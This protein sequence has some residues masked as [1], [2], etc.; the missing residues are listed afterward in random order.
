MV[1][2]LKIQRPS[3]YID[4]EVNVIRHESFLKVALAF[5]DI[6][7]VGMSHLGLRILYDIVNNLSFA[8]AERV[9]HPW[10]DMENALRTSGEP[11]RSLE[12][13]RPVTGFDV[14]GFSLQ[15]ELCYTSVLNMLDLGGVPL[16]SADRKD[17][18]PL[19]IAGG[20]CTVNPM[21]MAPFMDA[22]LI[23]DGEEAVPELLGVLHEWKKGGSRR[24]DEV[25][26]TLAQVEGVYV[27]QIHD[28]DAAVRIRRRYIYS[29]EE[30][31]CPTAPIV[32]YAQIV[33][34]RVNI[35]VSRGCTK[36]CRFCQAGMVYRPLRE[37]SP[38]KVLELASA[39]LAN[40]GYE[41][42]AFTSLS[43]GDYTGLL[44]LLKG[45]NQRFS[46]K[47]ISVS[48]PSLR[49]RAVNRDV[50]QEIR[51]VRKTGFTIAPE[52]GTTR[53]RD[54]INKDF[55]AEDYARALD[56]L[57]Q[58]GWQ[59][60][61]LYF[62]LGL[63]TERQ[64]DVEAIIDMV[65]FAQKTARKY[66]KRQVKINV[67][68]SP[69]VPKAHTPFQWC[70]QEDASVIREKKDFL[71]SRL[72]RVQFRGHDERMSMLEAAF[73]RGGT[74]LSPLLEASWRAGARLDGWSEAFRME[75]WEKGQEDSGLE[76]AKQAAKSYERDEP[77]PWEMIETGVSKKFLYR[78]YE[79]ALEAKMSPD[80]SVGKCTGC[81][82]G[83]RSEG[84][85][86]EPA[87][88]RE[89]K[90]MVRSAPQ[91]PV[92]KPIRVRVCFSKTGP[93]RYLSHRELITHVT[94]ALRRVGVTLEFSKGFHP[95]PRISFG[96]PLGVGVAGTNEFFDMEILPLISLQEIKERLNGVLGEG[97]EIKDLAPIDSREQ[98]LQA[99]VTRYGYD[100]VCPD[101]ERAVAFSERREC[102]V[103]R[104][105]GAVDIRPLV[106]SMERKTPDRVRLML[107]DREDKRVR[108]EEIA[109]E[110]F[111]VELAELD[112]TRFALFGKKDGQWSPPLEMERSW[113]QVVS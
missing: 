6:Y 62:M 35:E 33:H 61:K 31:P 12:F 56:T 107:V 102:I 110:V 113:P 104:E 28:G 103:K 64:E 49:V 8:S 89:S 37:R 81:G 51:S 27:P 75:A 18:D 68:A 66:S 11:L 79:R 17:G 109:R 82:L 88:Y 34:D 93:L 25:L 1:N 9:F 77:L 105:K 52:A 22:F 57:F 59:T 24:R 55:S 90:I 39:S 54:V 94:R 65:K 97:V 5:P 98:S 112:V 36:G 38:G 42:V 101:A 73:A 78:E 48:L 40:T 84:E 63:P 92:R 4:H 99:F 111:G 60:L 69:F 29:L 83:C 108:L 7:D 71:R 30:A 85:R 91:T 100:V 10:E 70:G 45:F 96:P 95:A 19:V 23:G 26:R 86:A 41:D 44:P 16:R 43:A 2:L 50:L 72:K 47:R 20:P 46:D 53:L 58:E 87:S 80:C 106:D 14:V 76:I 13:N 3:R 67:S 32:P 74:E 15:Y 21:P